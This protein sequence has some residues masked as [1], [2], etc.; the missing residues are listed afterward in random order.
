MQIKYTVQ[1]PLDFVGNWY[2][3]AFNLNCTDTTGQTCEPYATY[4]NQTQNWHNWD[5][6]IIVG[7]ANSSSSVQYVM[8]QFQ[9]QQTTNGTQKV[10]LRVPVAPQ[11]IVLNPNCNG[12]QTQFCLTIFRR[13]FNGVQQT[14]V[15]PTPTPA[16]VNGPGG[17]W[18]VNWMVASPQGGPGSLAPGAAV[19]AP[20]PQ[21]INDQTFQYPAGS[22]GINVTTAFDLPWTGQLPP[23][24]AQAPAPSAQVTGGE[25]INN[26]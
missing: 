4:G 14:G 6:E 9:T 21:G 13:V 26:P 18:Y 7:Q 11:D 19:W 5:F 10:A 8:W 25:V 3:L 1:G 24:W 20:G 16:P 2:V 22:P 15:S 17:V 12:N 23:T